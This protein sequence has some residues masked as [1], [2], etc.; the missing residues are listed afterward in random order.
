MGT[1]LSSE[2]DAFVRR[3]S[4]GMFYVVTDETGIYL[5]FAATR[6]RARVAYFTDEAAERHDLEEITR[7]LSER[8]RQVL[9]LL[10]EGCDTCE[11]ASRLRLSVKTIETYR[12]RI[13]EKLGIRNKTGLLRTAVELNLRHSRAVDRTAESARM[14]SSAG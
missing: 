13:K 5:V 7:A 10:G 8:E 1:T 2:A 12:A 6:E 11:I 9:D 14:V 3:L 4:S